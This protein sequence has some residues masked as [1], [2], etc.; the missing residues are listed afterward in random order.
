MV[1]SNNGANGDVEHGVGW[2]SDACIGIVQNALERI[3]IFIEL[4][5]SSSDNKLNAIL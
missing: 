1:L 4:M 3:F 5:V 2:W